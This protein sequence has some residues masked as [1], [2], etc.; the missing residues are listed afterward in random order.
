MVTRHYAPGK[1]VCVGCVRI[2]KLLRKV[3]NLLA[4]VSSSF[5]IEAGIT[6]ISRRQASQGSLDFG[7]A[8]TAVAESATAAAEASRSLHRAF[9]TILSRG[10]PAGKSSEAVGCGFASVSLTCGSA[11]QLIDPNVCLSKSEGPEVVDPLLHR[12]YRSIVGCLSYLVNMT[13]PDLAFS[14]SQLSKFLQY[15]GEAVSECECVDLLL[16]KAAAHLN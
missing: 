13:R 5:Q 10:N 6:P 9:R 4:L 3:A 8:S 12:K 16:V 11:P 14:F 15:P 2:G 1:H 7:V